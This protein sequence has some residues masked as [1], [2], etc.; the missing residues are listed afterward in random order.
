MIKSIL[1]RGV[2]YTIGIVFNRIVPVKLFRFRI[3]CVYELQ[4]SSIENKPNPPMQLS[5][6]ES[7]RELEQAKGLTHFRTSEDLVSDRYEVCLA[8]AEGSAD[9]IGGVWRAREQFDEEELG[10]RIKLDPQQAWIFAAYVAKSHR[11]QGV[12]A[13]LLEHV[14]RER[15]Q[16]IHFASINPTNKPSIAAH[17][18]FIRRTT[19][20]CVAIR[21]FGICGCWTSA[22]L[23]RDRSVSFSCQAVPIEVR[24]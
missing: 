14:L 10:V 13:A 22:G 3:F 18:K 19:G 24:F 7:D 8:T 11:G 6:C 21:I 15:D 2:F 16:V 20:T 23:R 5:W 17:R 9:P 4:R 1:Q 12:Y